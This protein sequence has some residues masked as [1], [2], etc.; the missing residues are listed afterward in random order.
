MKVLKNKMRDKNL[1]IQINCRGIQVTNL[2]T[3]AI[4]TNLYTGVLKHGI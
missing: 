2:S 1:L 4:E 3:S